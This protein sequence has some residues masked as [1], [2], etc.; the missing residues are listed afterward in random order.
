MR[1]CVVLHAVV[2]PPPALK[3]VIEMRLKRRGA[4][5]FHS[6][7]VGFPSQKETCFDDCGATLPRNCTTNPTRYFGVQIFPPL[8]AV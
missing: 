1:D 6:N 3:C 4:L 8:A 7:T 5:K 2:C